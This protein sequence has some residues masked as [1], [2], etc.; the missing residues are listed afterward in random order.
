MSKYAAFKVG[1]L[2]FVLS[3]AAHAAGDLLR[4]GL[5][6]FVDRV[7]T[8]QRAC[9]VHP[10]LAMPFE[11]SD[12]NC[13]VQRKASGCSFSCD[14][15][16]EKIVILENYS[17]GTFASSQYTET[18]ILSACLEQWTQHYALKECH[19]NR[20]QYRYEKQLCIFLPKN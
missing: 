7:P 17:D 4:C 15:E 19:E 10:V 12:R 8:D 5:P 20:N 18:S 9:V 2:V 14:G 6:T 3:F 11:A 16:P 13:F 1:L